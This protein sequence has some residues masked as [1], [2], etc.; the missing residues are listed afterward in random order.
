MLFH[1]FCLGLTQENPYNEIGC[2]QFVAEANSPNI[3][4]QIE[5]DVDHDRDIYSIM[6]FFPGVELL[7]HINNHGRFSENQAREMMRQLVSALQVLQNRGIAHRDLSLENIL[8]DPERELFS[9][10]DFGMCVRCPRTAQSLLRPPEVLDPSCFCPIR[11]RPPCGK[12]HYISPG[13]SA[14]KPS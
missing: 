1:L 2:L 5:C 9:I 6:S 14:W 10:I 8:F 4:G 11:R 7:S 12:R 3:V 13:K